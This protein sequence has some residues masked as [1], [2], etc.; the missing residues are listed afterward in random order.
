MKK[1]KYEWEIISLAK[2]IDPDEAI[3]ELERIESV[4]GSL[5]PENIL[6]ASKKRNA[7][8][9]NIFL[10][11]NETAAHAY[12]LQQARNLINNLEITII[13]DGEERQM[14]VFESIV[15]DNKRMYKNIEQLTPPD[16]EQIRATAICEI[17]A[18][19]NKLAFFSQFAK[20]TKKLDQAVTLLN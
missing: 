16:V 17:N 14:P 2:G 4:Y 19:K 11:D 9:H 12:R 8:L 13:S 20:A 6:D 7:V 1:S 5:T 15:K 10:W 18:W 3:L